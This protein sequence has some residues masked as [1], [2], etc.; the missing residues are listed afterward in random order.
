MK[1]FNKT[2]INLDSTV[3]EF[4]SMVH[5]LS[6]ET[7]F[8]KGNPRRMVDFGTLVIVDDELQPLDQEFVSF[9]ERMMAVDSGPIFTAPFKWKM[10][11][12]LRALGAFKSA[13]AAMKNGWDMDVPE[14]W[15]EHFM[16]ISKVKGVLTTFKVSK[17]NIWFKPSVDT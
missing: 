8:V 16:R 5:D 2:P 14:G 11:H 7:F 1:F 13:S 4:K 3:F 17:E 12:I 10:P 15:N 6:Q 9:I